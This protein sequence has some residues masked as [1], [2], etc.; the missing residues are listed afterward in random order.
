M[1]P[2]T[3]TTTTKLYPTRWGRLHESDDTIVSWTQNKRNGLVVPKGIIYVNESTSLT[4][5]KDCYV[6]RTSKG[7]KIKTIIYKYIFSFTEKN[8]S[9]SFDYMMFS[10]RKA[11]V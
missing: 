5:T 4:A 9:I 3:T 1:D 6:P 11:F 7:F 8:T 10:M 2:T